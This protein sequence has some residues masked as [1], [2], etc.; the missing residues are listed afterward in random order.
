MGHVRV[1]SFLVQLSNDNGP[2]IVECS[3]FKVV[4]KGGGRRET[5]EREEQTFCQKVTFII[6]MLVSVVVGFPV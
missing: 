3:M 5:R 1:E 2:N 6:S 4:V